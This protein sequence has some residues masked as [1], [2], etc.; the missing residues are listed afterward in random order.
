[1]WLVGGGMIGDEEIGIIFI[2]GR[3]MFCRAG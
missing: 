1:M 2:Y 3:L